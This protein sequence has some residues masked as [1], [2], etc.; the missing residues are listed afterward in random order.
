MIMPN[1]Y[2]QTVLILGGAR[3]GKSSLAQKM[4]LE[5]G[6]PVVYLAT[7]VVTDMEM[8]VRVQKH[9]ESRPRS[10]I[11]KETP[12]GNFSQMNE[13]WTGKAV[14]LDCITFLVNN[15][16]LRDGKEEIAYQ[17]ILK[18]LIFLFEKQKQ[19]NFYFL[20]VSNE[21]GMGIVPEYPLARTFRDLQGRINQWLAVR[22]T[23]VYIVIA[24]IP[25]K[26]KGEK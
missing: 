12:Y 26:I 24:G 6:L 25:V 9:R 15:Y 14:L 13:N 16:L 5:S 20:I 18:E 3:S 2:N 11:T 4:A 10:W 21:T 1:P 23:N 8:E 17:Q 22:A 19:E 7:G